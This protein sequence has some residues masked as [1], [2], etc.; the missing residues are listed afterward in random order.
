MGIGIMLGAAATSG[1]KTYLQL[2]QEMRDQKT[3]QD[4]QDQV[5]RENQER[6]EIQKQG[7]PSA[8]AP[9]V[10]GV[11]TDPATGVATGAPAPG[12]GIGAV[13]TPGA[14]APN[15]A[16]AAPVLSG[17]GLTS[18]PGPAPAAPPTPSPGGAVMDPAASK[19]AAIGFVRQ[20]EGGYTGDDAGKGP[21]KYGIN[22]QA[23]GLSPGQTAELTSDQADQIYGSKYWNSIGGDH[24]PPATAAVAMDAAVNNGPQRAQAWLA[25]SGGDPQKFL[26][27]R[28]NFYNKLSQD[29]KYAP[30]ANSWNNRMQDLHT[31]VQ[32]MGTKE[33]GPNADTPVNPDVKLTPIQ[34]DP[35]K[36]ANVSTAS[37]GYASRAQALADAAWHAQ[38][39]KNFPTYQK[40]AIDAQAHQASQHVMDLI[41]NDKLSSDEKVG[42][43]AG[44]VGVQAYKTE[45]GNYIMPGVGPIDAKGNPLPM[46][47]GQVAATAQALS[48]PDGLHYLQEARQKDQEI[49]I[50]QQQANTDQQRVAQ[51]APLT[52]AQTAEAQGNASLAPARGA[53][54]KASAEASQATTE[55]ENTSADTESQI[56]DLGTKVTELLMRPDASTNPAVMQQVRAYQAQADLLR[57]KSTVT[58]PEKPTEFKAGST[59]QVTNPD[60]TKHM[61]YQSP[62]VGTVAESDRVPM[63]QG[64]ADIQANKSLYANGRPDN[65]SIIWRANRRWHQ[66]L[67]SRRGCVSQR[68]VERHRCSDGVA[69]IVGCYARE[70]AHRPE[71]PSV[72]R[73]GRHAAVDR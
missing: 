15:G 28:Q 14:A 49:G 41:H 58:K 21:T 12:V 51:Q 25:Q 4:Q 43:L 44:S 48:S 6:S 53:Q 23:N 20:H 24:L 32:H 5:N 71:L 69:R 22:G 61:V 52:A 63:E 11:T 34:V 60:G 55:A 38:D 36:L 68:R 50:R 16:P 70:R 18:I 40:M 67:V 19:A 7:Q 3:F 57:G 62:T 8:P 45:Q 17:Q 66:Q 35:S 72:C 64:F 59:Y 1:M 29:P 37:S 33:T 31:F 39:L 42:A 47:F 27:L 2:S 26:T 9:S 73:Q 30:F 54:M 65:G 10:A 46:T 13:P 56:Q